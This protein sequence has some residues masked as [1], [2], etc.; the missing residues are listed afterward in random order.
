MG[1]GCGEGTGTAAALDWDHC[2]LVAGG[3]VE[4]VQHCSVGT[5]LCSARFWEVTTLHKPEQSHRDHED[6]LDIG[7]L[8]ED[9][10][11][12]LLLASHRPVGL[13]RHRRVHHRHEH[14]H[15]HVPDR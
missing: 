2:A 7:H 1:G 8:R 10:L 13:L 12:A 3:Q 4:L 15:H 5:Q 9:V 14:H 6:P 11:V